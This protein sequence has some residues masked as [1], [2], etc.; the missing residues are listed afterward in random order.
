MRM[1]DKIEITKEIM[2]AARDYVPN[3]EKE[4]WAAENATKCFDKLSIKGSDGEPAP[5]MYMV[6]SG[7][8]ARYLMGAFVGMY[9][10]Q[11]FE[12]EQDGSALMSEADYDRWA[13]SHAINQIER[14]K[15]DADLRD[16]CYDM[17][18]DFKDLEKRLSAQIS[19]LLSV[20][21]DP[22]MRQNEYMAAQVKQMPELLE[23]LKEFQ[24]KVEENGA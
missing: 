20:M 16:K 9:L 15:R 10:G 3:A 6:N 24:G 13:G 4:A 7:L 14:W 17:L 1:S 12:A 22:V 19:G 23:Q 11:K 5:D 21:N 8:K 18:S 2:L